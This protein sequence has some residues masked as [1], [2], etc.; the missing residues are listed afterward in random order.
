MSS[1]IKALSGR[2]ITLPRFLKTAKASV[3]TKQ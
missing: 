3:A 2:G 1:W